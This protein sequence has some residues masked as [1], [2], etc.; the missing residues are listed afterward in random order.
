LG[1]FNDFETKLSEMKVI[2]AASEVLEGVKAALKVYS[3]Y[4]K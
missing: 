1:T 2:E 4:T 3:A